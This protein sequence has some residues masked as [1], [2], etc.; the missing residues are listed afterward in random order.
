MAV[1]GVLASGKGSNLQALIEAVTSGMVSGRIGVVISDH[2][3]A[4][5]LSIARASAIPHYCIE[6][7]RRRTFLL[8]DIEKQ[9]IERLRE[10]RVE[11]LCLAGFMRILKA[12]LLSAFSGKILNIH[13]SLLPSFPGLEAWRQAIEYGVKFSG[14]TV[15]LVDGKGID[16]GRI[17]L[18][19]PVPVLP[20]DSPEILHRRIQKKEHILYPLALKLFLAE[21]SL[22]SG[23]EKK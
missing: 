16:T 12:D 11:I 18:Q 8:P 4:G 23:G 15:H 22:L 5:A 6:E 10:H 1:I 19:A 2:P 13:P 14:C 17:L 20:E 3:T 7:P 21:S 9:Y